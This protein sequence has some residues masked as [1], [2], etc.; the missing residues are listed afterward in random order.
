MPSAP[1]AF[2]RA[3]APLIVA[4]G[5]ILS[6]GATA[7]QT[8]WPM[9]GRDASHGGTIEGPSPPYRVTWTRRIP[10]G[11]V[12]GVAVTDESA[13]VVAE[14]T[15]V[16]L[17]PDDGTLLWIRARAGGPA[18]VPAL[19]KGLVLHASGEGDEGE[20]VARDVSDGGVV[21][22][23][24]LGSAA[25]GGPTVADETAFVGTEAGELVALDLSTGD[26]LWEFETL[27]EIRGPPAARDG[28]VVVV[29]YEQSSARS[30]VY[31]VDAEAGGEDG[32]LWRFE[33]GAV[34]PPSAPSIG[35]DLA[36]VGI[37]D[38][39][40]R[41]LDLGAGDE[42]WVTDVRDGFGPRQVP[43][44]GAALVL[45]DRTHAYRLDPE[46]GDEAWNYL[47]ADLAELEEG[48][49]NTLLATAPAI[50]GGTV[51]LGSGGG[52]LSAIDLD[53]GHRVW[54][55]DMGSLAV[56]PVAATED[57]I[58]AVTLGEDGAVT[59]FEHDPEGRLLDEVS[60]TVLFV[61][62]ALLNFA[63]AA[64]AVGTAILLLFRL[65]LRPRT[66]GRT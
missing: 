49:L 63:A 47:L 57:H 66:G 55:H 5:S 13:V 43:A 50:T 64:V 45:A 11:P 33:A 37:S 61:G 51:L 31:A 6:P 14:G 27:G 54:R 23:A 18:G 8:G 58:Y 26:V 40:V 52:T 12:G 46:T 41:A 17:D 30:T 60:P 22:E 32:P 24:G 15:V 59:A 2:L 39:S 38:L 36:Y 42:V 62:R 53:T 7:A 10:G 19:A 48:R 1:R 9:A 25:R 34:G 3:S 21:W 20:L 28:T 44:A 16:A 35:D 56:G 4:L 65:I 29:A